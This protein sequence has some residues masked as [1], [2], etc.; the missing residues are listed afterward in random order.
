MSVVVTCGHFYGV[1]LSGRQGLEAQTEIQR[2]GRAGWAAGHYARVSQVQQSVGRAELVIAAGQARG[3]KAPGCR[4]EDTETPIRFFEEHQKD[5]VA[6]VADAE[7]QRVEVVPVERRGHRP[8]EGVG[9]R[10]VGRHGRLRRQQREYAR[11][12]AER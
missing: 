12:R 9:D 5:N 1:A 7:L 6:A 11:W 2:H 8:G 3:S 4:I 10:L